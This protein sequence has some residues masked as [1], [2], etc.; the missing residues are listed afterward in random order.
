M[1]VPV[2]GVCIDADL[3]YTNNIREWRGD[4]DGMTKAAAI[5][6]AGSTYLCWTDGKLYVLDDQG[7]WQ[8]V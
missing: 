2:E 4:S 6:G 3:K 7:Q 8:E 1:P 5:S